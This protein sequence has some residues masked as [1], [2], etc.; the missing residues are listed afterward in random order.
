[1]KA[2]RTARVPTP[3]RRLFAGYPGE[4][5]DVASDDDFV[6][7]RLAEEGDRADL[8]WLIETA[9]EERLARAV[10]RRGARQL[11]AR[12]LAFLHLVLGLDPPPPP[13]TKDLWPL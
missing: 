3:A 5:L 4:A 7:L 11:S 13:R 8:A 12:S 10:R 1:M 6:A 2:D 9:G